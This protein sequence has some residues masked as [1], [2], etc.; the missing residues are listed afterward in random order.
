MI[1]IN[2]FE[3]NPYYNLALEEYL[4]NELKEDIIMLWQNKDSVIIGKNQNVYEE[5][6]LK[7]TKENNINIVRRETGGGAVF[8]DLGNINFTFIFEYDI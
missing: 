4:L 8:H 2:N 7:Y 5:I 1:Y 3:K 6:N